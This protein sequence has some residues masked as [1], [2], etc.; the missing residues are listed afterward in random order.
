MPSGLG[1]RAVRAAVHV[2]ALA[3]V[4]RYQVVG[5]GRQQA[6]DNRAHRLAGR[7]HALHGRGHAGRIPELERPHLP[8]EPGPHGAVHAGGIVGDL[9]QAIRRV[10]PQA[11]SAAASG[12]APPCPCVHRR[13]AVAP[14]APAAARRSSPFRATGSWA[15]SPERI[16][17]SSSPAPAGP[18]CPRRPSLSCRSPVWSCRPAS[19]A[20][21][22]SGRTAASPPEPSKFAATCASTSMPT[23]SARRKVPVRGQPI[24]R[25]R[26]ARPP[27]RW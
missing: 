3:A 16:P 21:A 23:M 13:P 15:G 1:D 2:E 7:A 25:A 20:P 12:N 19:A 24:A 6:F 22:W 14:A 4:S 17:A 9:R 27:P 18:P 8:V 5:A 11:R 10:V 26:S